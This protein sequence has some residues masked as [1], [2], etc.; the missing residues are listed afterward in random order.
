MFA[1][2][3]KRIGLD[4]VRILVTGSAPLAAHVTEFVRIVFG[5]PLIDP[6][7]NPSFAQKLNAEIGVNILSPPTAAATSPNG[8]RALEFF[9]EP[10]GAKSKKIYPYNRFSSSTLILIGF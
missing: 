8:R 5:A 4:R 2:I 3:K 6:D 7:Y 1:P 10:S 9:A